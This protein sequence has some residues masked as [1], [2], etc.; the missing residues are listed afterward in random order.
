MLNE[1]IKDQEI[2]TDGCQIFKHDRNI[3]DGRVAFYVKNS[4][5]DVN[6]NLKS[7]ELELLCLENTPC[8][9]K[10]LFLLSWYRPPIPDISKTD[11]NNPRENLR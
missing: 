6:V 2:Q 8:N 5:T 11:F 3:D 4:L 7:D 9:A 1:T 10:S